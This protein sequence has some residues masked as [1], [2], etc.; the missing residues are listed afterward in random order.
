MA[1]SV[2]QR[3][4]PPS[5]RIGNKAWSVPLCRRGKTKNAY[6]AC[7][8]IDIRLISNIPF[9]YN[10]D[11]KVGNPDWQCTVFLSEW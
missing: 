4:W 6:P 2:G 7:Q 9:M 10:S 8:K 1:K 11:T 3:G 5:N